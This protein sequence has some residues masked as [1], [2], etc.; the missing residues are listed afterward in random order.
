MG[1]PFRVFKLSVSRLPLPPTVKQVA[2]KEECVRVQLLL[3][4]AVGSAEIVVR[5]EDGKGIERPGAAGIGMGIDEL[6]IGDEDEVMRLRSGG[7]DGL[8]VC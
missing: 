4:L 8:V 3:Q 5:D 2:E 6:G 1:A 7:L